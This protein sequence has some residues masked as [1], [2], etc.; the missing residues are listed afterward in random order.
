[1]GGQP[2]RPLSGQ[3]PARRKDVPCKRTSGTAAHTQA[4][5]RTSR[6]G[7]MPSGVAEV[8]RPHAGA[9]DRV[10]PIKRDLGVRS[11]LVGQLS[12][13]REAIVGSLIS[14]RGPK[15]ISASRFK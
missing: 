4:G 12:P 8:P 6:R 9:A 10:R 15:V 1:M 13:R 3:S 2:R 7:N 14:S 11:H 5:A